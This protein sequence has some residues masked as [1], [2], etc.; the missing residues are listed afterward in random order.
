MKFC[1]LTTF[2]GSHSFGGDAV[3]VERLAVALLKRGHQVHVIYSVDAFNLLRKR[4]VERFYSP[5][6]ELVLHTVHS[7]FGSL[8][9]LVIHQTGGL[10]DLRGQIKSIRDVFLCSSC[11]VH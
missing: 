7:P 4:T 3:A 6:P 8:S 2:F 10:S 1:L 11:L 5:I 9:Q